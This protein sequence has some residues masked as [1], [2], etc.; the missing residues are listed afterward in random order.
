MKYTVKRALALL[1]A[2]LL[3]L[4]ALASA[5]DV[6]LPAGEAPVEDVPAD[7]DFAE[8][9]DPVVAE[10]A[11]FGE[12]AEETAWEAAEP[13][14]DVADDAPDDAANDEPAEETAEG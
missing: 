4:P 2:L 5:E 14:D 7:Q 13:T 12:A 1:I 8:T 10:P 6:A 11:A 9:A 3:A